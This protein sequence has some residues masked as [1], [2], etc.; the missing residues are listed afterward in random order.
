MSGNPP[1]GVTAADINKHFSP[2]HAGRGHEFPDWADDVENDFPYVHVYRY[3]VAS[4]PCD[5][6]EVTTFEV[7]GSRTSLEERFNE[8]EWELPP[9]EVEGA[10]EASGGP[11]RGPFVV[12]HDTTEVSEF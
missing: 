12:T 10:Y 7:E 1:P 4:D 3:C 11:Y 6:M 5:A 9:D 8:V 2:V